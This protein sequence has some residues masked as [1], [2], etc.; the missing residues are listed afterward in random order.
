MRA[1]VARRRLSPADSLLPAEDLL[2]E[3]VVFIAVICESLL[4]ALFCMVGDHDGG[5]GGEDG[6][7]YDAFDY[8]DHCCEGPVASREA[9]V[10]LVRDCLRVLLGLLRGSMLFR[11]C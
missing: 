8:G 11:C 1:I 10:M 3:A 2:V 5:D 6:D 7:S 9:G 4:Q